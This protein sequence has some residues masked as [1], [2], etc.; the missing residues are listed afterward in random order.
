M[1]ARYIRRVT[2]GG[3]AHRRKFPAGALAALECPFMSQPSWRRAWPLFALA[4]AVGLVFLVQWPLQAIRD[5]RTLGRYEPTTCA[6]VSSRAVSSTTSG[7]I[8]R[9]TFRHEYAHP[10]VTFR[11]DVGGRTYTRSGYDN[12]DG[13]QSDASVLVAY[14]A[15]AR[16]A[17]WYDP[18]HPDQAVVERSFSWVY[19][20]S[21]LI[22]LAL[23][24]IP[25]NFLLVALRRRPRPIEL[26]TSA[27]TVHAVRLAPEFTNRQALAYRAGAAIVLAAGLVAYVGYLVR[28][29]GLLGSLDGMGFFFLGLVA[30]DGYIFWLAWQSLRVARLQDPTVEVDREPARPG[31]RVSVAVAI[32]GPL[33][34]RD[35]K[36]TL[37]SAE[38]GPRG[39]RKPVR[40]RILNEAA[41]TIA[42]G[43]WL[44]RTATV[45]IPTDARPSERG[46]DRVTTWAIDLRLAVSGGGSI[47]HEYPFR[48]I[49]PEQDA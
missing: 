29:D 24:I 35:L 21:G 4:T 13:S 8:G 16:V 48:V 47:A 32:P 36:L 38:Q 30:A 33:T 41:G 37:V 10:E 22:P 39:S 5:Y 15:G 14:A 42:E 20:A 2:A 3:S 18:A 46:G 49:A 17:C 1:L 28:Q 44:T 34:F 43:A 40:H 45:T 19:Y 25:G 31:D 12:Y 11:Y 26:A 6:V 7:W 23:T 27:G 9:R